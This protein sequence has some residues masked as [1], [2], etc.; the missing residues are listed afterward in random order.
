MGFPREYLDFTTWYL[1][2][3]KYITR[4]DNSDFALTALGVD[5]VEENYTKSPI[6]HE[7]LG[8]GS[9]TAHPEDATDTSGHGS[10][11]S[12]P[13]QLKSAEALRRQAEHAGSDEAGA[14]IL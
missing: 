4:E 14:N 11:P 2:A 13:L 5:Y 9:G 6:L 3:K 7:L 10:R 12:T 8:T 1:R